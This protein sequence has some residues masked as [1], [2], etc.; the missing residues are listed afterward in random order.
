MHTGRSGPLIPSH[1]KSSNVQSQEDRCDAGKQGRALVTP[2]PQWVLEESWLRC[3]VGAPGGPE[4][5]LLTQ[6]LGLLRN[7]KFLCGGQMVMLLALRARRQGDSKVLC[8]ECVCM[9]SEHG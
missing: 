9:S 6:P 4:T 7:I 1:P 3:S 5:A 2:A 8:S